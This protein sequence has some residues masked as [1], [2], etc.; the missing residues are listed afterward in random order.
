MKTFSFFPTEVCQSSTCQHLADDLLNHSMN[1]STSPC[2]DF[3]EYICGNYNYLQLLNESTTDMDDQLENGDTTSTTPTTPTAKPP[4]IVIS[5]TMYTRQEMLNEELQQAFTAV[6]NSSFTSKTLR[7]VAE[8]Y[9]ECTNADS[10][11]FQG[12]EPLVQ[13]I[14]QL[15]GGWPMLRRTVNS[16]NSGNNRNSSSITKWQDIFVNVYSKA[17]LNYIFDIRN[18]LSSVRVKLC[19]KR[20]FKI[21]LTGFYFI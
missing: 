7:A 17:G 21:V 8:L 15:V 1:S 10:R 5:G 18:E 12:T 14:E 11:E 4:N 9:R 19:F 20:F 13:Y 16:S 3:Y 2:D 6:Q